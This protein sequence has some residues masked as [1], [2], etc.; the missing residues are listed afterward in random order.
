MTTLVR[1]HE[2]HIFSSKFEVRSC[3]VES[4]QGW[5]AKF[6]QNWKVLGKC[7]FAK[8]VN[9]CT[10]QQSLEAEIETI[11]PITRIRVPVHNILEQKNNLSDMLR[12][13]CCGSGSGY[14]S[15]SGSGYGSES[16]S[17]YG[18]ES[19]SVGFV[20][21]SASLIRIR[22][23]LSEAWIRTWIRL[24]IRMLLPSGK[25]T[26]TLVSTIL[27]LLF[28]FLSLKNDVNVPSK[29]NKMENLFLN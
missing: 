22:I 13:Q 14:G 19:G 9:I 1:I 7:D 29:S 3:T 5:Q 10:R 17:G 18:S 8:M 28:D 20:C 27:L 21:F 12:G 25:N 15:E 2:S 23:H 16:G 6:I 24:R 26:K 11:F 4:L